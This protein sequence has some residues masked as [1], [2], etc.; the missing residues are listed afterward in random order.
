MLICWGCGGK[1]MYKEHPN[2]NEHQCVALDDFYRKVTGYDS[3][4]LIYFLG[5]WEANFCY[6]NKYQ[7]NYKKFRAFDTMF[8]EPSKLLDTVIFSNDS[9]LILDVKSAI[10]YK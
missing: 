8:A 4:Q 7:W 10:Y 5:K 1:V 9:I 3:V 2:Y 6:P